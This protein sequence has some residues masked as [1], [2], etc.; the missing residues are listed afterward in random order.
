M[1]LYTISTGLITSVL[2]VFLPVVFATYGFHVS[3]LAIALP[4]PTLHPIT[5][6]AN[7]HMRTSLRAR[8]DTPSPLE[9]ISY[10][11]KKGLRRNV[12][13]HRSRGPTLQK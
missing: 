3:G 1:V 12:G 7:L 11:I 8:L 2:S 9:L 4:L 5:M 13:D 10:S 6:L